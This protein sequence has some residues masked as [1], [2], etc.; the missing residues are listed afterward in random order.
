MP[1]QLLGV[2]EAAFHRLLASLVELLAG[3]GQS[4]GIDPILVVLPHVPR[5]RFDLPR[6]ACTGIEPRTTATDLRVTA[7]VAV[8]ISIRRGVD[9]R[10]T[11][12]ALIDVGGRVVGEGAFGKIALEFTGAAIADNA[13]EAALLQPM[14]DSRRK[15]TGVE[16]DRIKAE[17]LALMIKPR[18]VRHAIVHT[19]R[20]DMGI[21]N[22]GVFAVDRA[23]IQVKEA[24]RLAITHHV[25]AIGV[26]KADLLFY[27]GRCIDTRRQGFFP[28]RAR[29]SS[30]A[31]SV[32]AM[33]RFRMRKD[34][35]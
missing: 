8:A 19:G 31:T 24:R 13:M 14:A 35:A 27:G 12:R 5:D 17:A 3:L 4:P 10:L 7:I 30:T 28:C 29:P 9:Q 16:A 15:V 20:G 11:F 32:S 34:R 6:V 18:Q 33:A 2:G 23:E 25:A 21:G 22:N 1:V 26:G